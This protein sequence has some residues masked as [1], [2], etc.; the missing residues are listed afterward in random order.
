[1]VKRK[2]GLT[3]E[4][5]DTNFPIHPIVLS[6]PPKFPARKICQVLAP[7][8]GRTLCN[9]DGDIYACQGSKAGGTVKEQSGEAVVVMTQRAQALRAAEQ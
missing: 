7:Q 5:A 2:T 1:M 6:L 4:L 9:D 3:P 8:N